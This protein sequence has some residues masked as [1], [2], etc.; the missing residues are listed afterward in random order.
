MLLIQSFGIMVAVLMCLYTYLQFR[1]KKLGFMPTVFWYIFWIS[2]LI[3]SLLPAEQWTLPIA[4]GATTY[5]SVL[6][7]VLI[8][9]FAF[10]YRLSTQI[11]RT[12]KRI[13]EM[14][15]KLALKMEE[16]KKK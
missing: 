2:L 5:N 7:F 3:V 12:N 15:Q 9:I 6:V 10:I 8:V 16:E 11:Y 14:V 13:E 1:K 4:T